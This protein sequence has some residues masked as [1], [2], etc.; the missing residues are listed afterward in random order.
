MDISITKVEQLND[1]V[2]VTGLVN[3]QEFTIHCWQSHLDQLKNDKERQ[4]Y[5]AGELLAAYNKTIP[6]SHDNLLGDFTIKM[7]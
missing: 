3:G 7:K 5:I 4:K 1:D 6:I 2:N